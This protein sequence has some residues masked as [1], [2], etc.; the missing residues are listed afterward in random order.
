MQDFKDK[1]A[2]ITG[3]GRGIGQYSDEGAYRSLRAH[4][5]DGGLEP[6]WDNPYR[7]IDRQAGSDGR[8]HRFRFQ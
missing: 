2:I 3:A 7:I 6:I 1:V 8:F 4:I 5:A